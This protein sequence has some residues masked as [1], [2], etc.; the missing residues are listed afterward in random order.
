MMKK[1][2]RMLFWK[3][4]IRQ[5]RAQP[6]SRAP[7]EGQRLMSRLKYKTHGDYSSEQGPVAGGSESGSVQ[8]NY[9]FLER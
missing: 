4:K 8:F 3:K 7:C 9:S 1:Q 2:K 6:K 5:P